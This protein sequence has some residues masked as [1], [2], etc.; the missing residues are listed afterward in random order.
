MN[1]KISFPHLGNYYHPIAKLIKNLT[2]ETV[3]ISPPITKKTLEIGTKYSPDTVCIPFKYNLGN[4]IESLNNGA[5]ILLTAGGGCRYRYYAEVTETIL[6]D[7]GYKFKF[8]KLIKKD[9]INLKEIYNMFK[10]INPHLSKK[11]FYYQLLL[12][13]FYIFYIDE[14]DKIIRKNIGFEDTNGAHEKL[15]QKM[16]KELDKATSLRSLTYLY[17]K[18]KKEFKK[19]KTVKPKNCL[20]VGIIGELYTNMEPFANYN[21]EKELAKQKIEIKR[22]TNL[23]YLLW[24]KKLQIRYMQKKVKKYCKYMLGADALDNIYRTIYLSNKKYDGIIHIKPFGCT[25]EI[26]AI[27]IIQK[28]CEEKNTPIIFFSYDEETGTEGMKTRLEAFQDLITIRRQNNEK[29]ISRN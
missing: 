5:N 13:I 7:L 18:Y 1:K 15:Q 8:Y 19:I 24:Q 23:S 4:F 21:L 17:K 3:I 6:K 25:P 22:F 11:E 29:R 28:I 2:K 20:K 10:E 16:L 26:T 27:P 9:K 12:T 14:I